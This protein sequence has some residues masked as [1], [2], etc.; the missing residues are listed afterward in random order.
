MNIIDSH[1]SDILFSKFRLGW[2]MSVDAIPLNSSSKPNLQTFMVVV[3]KELS[4]TIHH[5]TLLLGDASLNCNS[6]QVEYLGQLYFFVASTPVP[7]F[8]PLL[9][10]DTS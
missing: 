6:E 10:T 7:N 3:E 8:H 9:G 2:K 4:T 5:I 1:F